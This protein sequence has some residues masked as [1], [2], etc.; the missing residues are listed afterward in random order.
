MRI[1]DNSGVYEWWNTKVMKFNIGITVNLNSGSESQ[2]LSTWNDENDKI[3]SSNGW[4]TWDHVV[5]TEDADYLSPEINSNEF[6]IK[7]NIA[8][9]YREDLDHYWRNIE[10]ILKDSKMP[11][12]KPT[13]KSSNLE[14]DDY[15]ED[16]DEPFSERKSRYIKEKSSM[17]N[18]E[19]EKNILNDK[20]T[21]QAK[22]QTQKPS[23]KLKVNI[24]RKDALRYDD[25][26]WM[27]ELMENLKQKRDM[28]KK[29]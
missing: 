4:W 15:V 28:Q 19:E 17:Y 22:V 2:L 7:Q 6:T 16:E 26:D 23:D 10:I 14:F 18:F 21:I 20:T 8:C 13:Q 9:L 3:I 12:I 5:D 29:L 24:W 25:R 11:E 1:W 27:K